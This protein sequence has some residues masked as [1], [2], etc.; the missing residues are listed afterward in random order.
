MI[1][2]ELKAKK[3]CASSFQFEKAIKVVEKY[4]DARPR[5]VYITYCGIRYQQMRSCR[6]RLEKYMIYVG[7]Y[8]R[9]DY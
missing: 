3:L 6:G 4:C 9:E 1:K 5:S 8:K 7:L 2:K